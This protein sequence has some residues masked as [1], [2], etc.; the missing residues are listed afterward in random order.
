MIVTPTENCICL[1]DRALCALLV[2]SWDTAEDLELA[3]REGS[4]S[5]DFHGCWIRPLFSYFMNVQY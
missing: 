2:I 1:W 5:T 4:F 3:G